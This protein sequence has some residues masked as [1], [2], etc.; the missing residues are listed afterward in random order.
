MSQ[1]AAGPLR[2]WW[3]DLLLYDIQGIRLLQFA[4]REYTWLDTI[5][6]ILI[7]PIFF[8]NAAAGGVRTVRD[9]TYDPTVWRPSGP[10]KPQALAARRRA[11]SDLQLE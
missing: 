3:G 8:M 10:F 9:P 4:Q 2:D 5:M 11:E 6:T 1:D 7:F